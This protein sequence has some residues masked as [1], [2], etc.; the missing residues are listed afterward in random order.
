MEPFVYDEDKPHL[1]GNIEGGDSFTFCPGGWQYL[2]DNYRVRTVTD[3][4]CGQGHALKWFKDAGCFVI[5]VEGLQ[6]NVDKANTLL[7]EEV[8][9]CC[10]LQAGSICLP[11]SHL[12]WCCELVE[13][14][15]EQYIDNLLP[16]LVAPV[17]AMTHAEVNQ[18]GHHHVNCQPK[19]YWIEKL[20]T[21]G[22]V[23]DEELTE[24]VQACDSHNNHFQWH[25]LMFRRES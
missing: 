25:G 19:E 22:M 9:M 12:V 5:G 7:G 4:G 16:L 3:I 13:H 2:L 24:T 11:Q 15:E 8:V 20:A 6:S 17:L 23:Y 14:I 1:G 10:D 21:V 18:D